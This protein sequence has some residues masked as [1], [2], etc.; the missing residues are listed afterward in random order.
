[1]NPTVMQDLPY[2]HVSASRG[3]AWWRQGWR[4]FLRAPWAWVGLSV[5]LLVG[6]M[7]LH[8]LPLGGAVAQWLAMPLFTLGAVFASVLRRRWARARSITPEGL[9]AEADNDGAFGESSKQWG[10]R[11]GSL[12]LASLIV[13][14]AMGVLVLLLALG[15]AAL[16]G[17]GLLRLEAI[18]HMMEASPGAVLAGL[19]M[20][21][22]ALLAAGMLVLLVLFLC[23]VAFW[24]VGTLVALGGVAP[25]VAVQLS[26]RAALANLG[27]LLVFSVLLIPFTI[28]AMIPL[29]MGMLVLLPVISGASYASYDDVFGAA[30]GVY[31]SAPPALAP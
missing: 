4:S 12:L 1:M 27:A 5:A 24:F 31:A 19:G 30:P 23:S 6:S 29:G 22:G 10:S 14:L 26:V 11:L 18:G 13:L 7:V 25:W 15:L 28:L 21:A 8:M 3:L 2:R 20:G 17:V 16:F 9:A